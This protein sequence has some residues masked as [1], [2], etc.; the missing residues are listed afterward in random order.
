MRDDDLYY[1]QG[2]PPVTPQPAAQPAPWTETRVVGR[3]I[4]RIYAYDR[5]SGAA[6]YP[7]DTILPDRLYAA[8]PLA[9]DLETVSPRLGDAAGFELQEIDASV[10]EVTARERVDNPAREAAARKDVRAAVFLARRGIEAVL[11]R[12][13]LGGSEARFV[14]EQNGVAWLE[15]PGAATVEQAEA[16]LLELAGTL[17]T[18]AAALSAEG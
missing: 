11:V 16:A 17:L 5:V 10:R 9:E 7:S 14:L 8:I 12:E 13:D 1:M 4:P 18:D 6:R 2:P 15:R 3:P